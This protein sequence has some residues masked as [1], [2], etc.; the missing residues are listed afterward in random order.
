M[1]LSFEIDENRLYN[2]VLNELIR[3]TIDEA[4]KQI[5]TE[6][7]W[8]RMRRI[9][10]EDVHKSM[11]QIIKDHEEE[12][13]GKAISEAGAIIA[14]KAGAIVMGGVTFGKTD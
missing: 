12:I 9:Y 1:K 4:E 14:R 6:D 11:M 10:K 7:G 5:F 13:L 8:S 2:E 3:E